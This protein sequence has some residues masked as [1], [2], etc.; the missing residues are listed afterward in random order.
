MCRCLFDNLESSKAFHILLGVFI[1]NAFW[2]LYSVFTFVTALTENNGQGGLNDKLSDGKL[3][4][5]TITDGI[6]IYV[7]IKPRMDRIKSWGAIYDMIFLSK[8]SSPT[9]IVCSGLC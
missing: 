6:F 2:Q 8:T 4:L 3:S 7:Q 1:L 9:I 5:D